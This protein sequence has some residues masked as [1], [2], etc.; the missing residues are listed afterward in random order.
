MDMFS[1]FMVSLDN[2]L[3]IGSLIVSY[4]KNSGAEQL[5]DIEH[6][7]GFFGHSYRVSL[8]CSKL[9]QG[10]HQ[11]PEMERLGMVVSLT[12]KR[13]LYFI[14]A[15]MNIPSLR[16]DPDPSHPDPPI[17]DEI[18]QIWAE[19]GNDFHFLMLRSWSLIFL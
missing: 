19:G 16:S 12:C 11:C 1:L 8:I 3:V 17:G 13:K 10:E 15:S 18:H 7:F 4:L 2:S 5:N 6:Q 14:D 9:K